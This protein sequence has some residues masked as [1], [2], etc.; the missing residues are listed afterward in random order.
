MVAICT[1]IKQFNK[2]EFSFKKLGFSLFKSHQ[3]ENYLP[4]SFINDFIFCPRS[5]Y[6]H[7]LYRNRDEMLYQGERQSEGKAAH[8]HIDNKTYSDKKSVLQNFEIYSSKYLLFGKID[9]FDIDK[10]LLTERKKNIKTVYDGYIFQLFA[11]YF[12]LT[13]MGYEVKK[14]VLY[15]FS[16]NAVYPIELPEQN[17]TMLKKFE[18]TLTQIRQFSLLDKNFKPNKLKCENCIYNLLCD[19]SLC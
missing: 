12:G 6:N 18:D 4:I 19:Y 9:V 11:Q 3:L 1:K 8:Q 13:E 16:K 10:G 5:I 17:P 15:D 14:I 7:Q 2:A